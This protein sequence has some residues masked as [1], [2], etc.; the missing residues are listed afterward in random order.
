MHCLKC[1][2]EI[3]ATEVFCPECLAEGSRYPVSR[4][5]PVSIPPRPVYDP[6][7]QGRRQPKPEELLAQAKRRQR[8]WMRAALALGLACVALA[9]ALLIFIRN[10]PGKRA[11]GQNYITNVA[12]ATESNP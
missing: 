8:R 4:E 10:T 11:I 1:G 6:D 9:V 2:R 12:P 5:T 3:K 7:R